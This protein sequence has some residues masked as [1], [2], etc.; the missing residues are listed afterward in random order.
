M[1]LGGSLAKKAFR[2]KRIPSPRLRGR[3]RVG[4]QSNVVIAFSEYPP[5]PAPSREGRGDRK[6]G[7]CRFWVKLRLS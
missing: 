5:P 2:A 3:A 7:L 4:G 6:T 1:E